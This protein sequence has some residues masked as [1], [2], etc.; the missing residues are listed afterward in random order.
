MTRVSIL[1]VLLFGVATLNATTISFE[2]PLGSTGT[3][4]PVAARVLFITGTDTVTVWLGNLLENPASVGQALSGLA[5]IVY[6]PLAPAD[7]ASAALLSSE[8]LWREVHRGGAFTDLG[9]QPTGWALDTSG[10][11]QPGLSLCVLCTGL[12]AVGPER[13]ILGPPGPTGLYDNANGSIAGNPP[14]NPFLAETATYS[15]FLPGVTAASTITSATFSFGT[16]IG[17]SIPG[18]DP[19]VPE[20]GTWTL[21]LAG[22]GLIAGASLLKRSRMLRRRRGSGR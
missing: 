6:P 4:G 10:L 9:I 3:D 21:L 5:F 8:A 13:L 12:G 2:T 14:H 20:P 22:S 15:L 18:D 11:I 7:L 16:S 19:Q 1:I 17:N